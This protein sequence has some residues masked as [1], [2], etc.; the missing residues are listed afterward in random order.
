MFHLNELTGVSLY[1][2]YHHGKKCID[3]LKTLRLIDHQHPEQNFVSRFSETRNKLIEHNYN[4]HGL[5]LQIHPS[6]WSLG[7]ANSRLEINIHTTWHWKRFWRLHRLLWRLLSIRKNHYWHYK[8]IL[9]RICRCIRKSTRGIKS[10]KLTNYIWMEKYKDTSLL[11]RKARITCKTLINKPKSAI[12]KDKL[13]KWFTNPMNW[14][15]MR[16]QLW[17]VGN[18]YADHIFN[19][20]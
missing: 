16:L 8:D 3:L 1:G 12:W 4:P 15:E 20:H 6:I 13:T 5:K 10:F 2:M 18:S 9:G 19:T 11:L 14:Q 17:K 7:A